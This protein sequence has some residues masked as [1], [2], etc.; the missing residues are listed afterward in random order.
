M[1]SLKNNIDYEAHF[2]DLD[3][4]KEYYMPDL[5]KFP[6]QEEYA[7]DIKSS[8]SLYELAETLNR[9]SDVF[10]NG[11]EYSIKVY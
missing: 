8:E 3:K 1:E 4:A 10:G 7:K 9:Y 5:S 2:T 6:E 11:S